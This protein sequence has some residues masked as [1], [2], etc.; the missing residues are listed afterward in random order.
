[1]DPRIGAHY[2]N[3]SFGYGGY[4]LPK[5][6]KQLLANYEDVPNNIIGAIVEANRTRKDFIADQIL[7]RINFEKKQ[8]N[9]EKSV[10]GVYRLTM[11]SNSDNFRQSSIQGIMKRLKA[12][13]VEIVVYEPAYKEAFFFGSRVE[14]DL[15]K[16][17]EECE[18][19]ISNR[20]SDE[21]ADVEEKVYTRDLFSVD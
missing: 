4:C 1:M 3:P 14:R 5:D 8:E 18:L 13:G 16:F 20:K 15:Q 7:S 2:N 21:L 6:T 12:K 11:K 9:G 19:I 17:K 10:V